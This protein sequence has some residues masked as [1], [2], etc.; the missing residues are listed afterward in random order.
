MVRKA[1]LM[2]ELQPMSRFVVVIFDVVYAPVLLISFASGARFDVDSPCCSL[3]MLGVCCGKGSTLFLHACVFV[4]FSSDRLC[5]VFPSYRLS[6]LFNH[7][8]PFSLP[9]TLSA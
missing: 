2:S 3:F 9:S 1:L 6:Q 8:L 7:V 5:C 4:V